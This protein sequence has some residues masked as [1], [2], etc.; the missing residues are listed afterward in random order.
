MP[1]KKTHKGAAKRFK[2]TKNGK[3]RHKKMG[4]SHL[5]EKKSQK[6]KRNLR[7]KGLA[8]SADAKSIKKL[9]T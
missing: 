4:S 3:I 6:R 5:L 9:I 7:K 2:I 1:K 8:S